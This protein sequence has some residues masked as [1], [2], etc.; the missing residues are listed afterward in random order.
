M[1]A[2]RKKRSCSRYKCSLKTYGP[3]REVFQGRFDFRS[4]PDEYVLSIE[5]DDDSDIYTAVAG[6][7]HHAF[8]FFISTHPIPPGAMWEDVWMTGGGKGTPQQ[9]TEG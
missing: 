7:Y 5:V 1:A 8:Q 6:Y 9:P 3:Y 4:V 2:K